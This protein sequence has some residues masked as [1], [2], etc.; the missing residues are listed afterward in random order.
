VDLV[1]DWGDDGSAIKQNII[2][3]YPYLNGDYGWLVKSTSFY[4]QEGTT[5]T[6]ESEKATLGV[7]RMPAGCIFSD[8]GPA[9]F[10]ASQADLWWG[11]GILDSTLIAGFLRMLTPDRSRPIGLVSSFPMRI[12][13]ADMKESLSSAVRKDYDLKSAWDTGN[14]T[15]TSFSE[16][17]ILQTSRMISDQTDRGKSGISQVFSLLE[18]SLQLPSSPGV[19]TLSDLLDFIVTLEKEAD[20]ILKRLQDRIDEIVYS[21]YSVNLNDRAL[22]ERELGDPPPEIVWPHMERESD[23]EKR[24]EHIRRLL[25]Y[26]VLEALKETRDGI[27]PLCEG[28]GHPTALDAVRSGLAE[29]FG[30]EAAFRMEGEIAEILGRDIGDWL[31]GPFIKWHTSLYKS[32]PILWQLSSRDYYH[33]F[34]IF[35]YIHK[36]D[37]DTLRKVQTQYL[38]PKRRT[39]A[40][41][42][43]AAQADEDYGRLEDVESDLEALEAFEVKLLS[44]IEGEV[45]V[46]TPSWA[47]GPYRHGIYDPVLD[48]GVKVNIAPLQ[49]AY[50]LRYKRMV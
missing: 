48:D 29:T 36:L 37:A 47:E 41:A 12:P 6:R 23:E 13:N 21:V 17:W 19:Q 2:E 43:D 34:N 9:I 11:M 32:R 33:T 3:K 28:T 22:I 15:A 39:L 46:R 16:P 18:L 35:L 44:V 27:L 42:R 40:S 38:W 31:D 50:L 45:T 7:Y 14:E 25:S 5:Y 26:F 10:F 49:K 24:R 4:F 1:V 30:E 20:S 8:K